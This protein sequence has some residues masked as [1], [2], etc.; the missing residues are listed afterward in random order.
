MIV[1][2]VH[3]IETRRDV[4]NKD[5]VATIKEALELAEQGKLKAVA[6]AM[7]EADGSTTA[8]WSSSDVFG[9]LTGSVARLQHRLQIQADGTP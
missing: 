2:E 4:I 1:G 6:I 5:V 8:S 7:V 9:A 3:P